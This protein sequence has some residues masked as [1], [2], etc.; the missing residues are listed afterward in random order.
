MPGTESV[1]IRDNGT[2]DSFPLTID[3]YSI[4]GRD[5]TL[6]VGPGAPFKVFVDYGTQGDRVRRSERL[7]WEIGHP[8]SAEFGLVFEIL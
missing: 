6:I 1:L 8:V 7:Q 2:G 5:L 4:T 3:D